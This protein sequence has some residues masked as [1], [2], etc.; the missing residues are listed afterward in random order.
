MKSQ[1]KLVIKDWYWPRDAYHCFISQQAASERIAAGHKK[2]TLTVRQAGNA[3][4]Q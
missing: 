3:Q 1:I 2:K 4:K